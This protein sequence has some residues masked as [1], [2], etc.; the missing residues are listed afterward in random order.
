MSVTQAFTA[1]GGHDAALTRRDDDLLD[2]WPV[3]KLVYRMITATPLGWSTRLGLYGPW[4]SGKTSVL[5]FLQL[6]AE[7]KGDIIVRLPAWRTSGEQEF[8]VQFYLALAEA[9]QRSGVGEP[10]KHWTKRQSKKIADILEK[11]A[12]KTADLKLPESASYSEI[13]TLAAGAAGLVFEKL[14][15]ILQLEKSDLDAL[16]GQLGDRR[17][18]VFV[19]DLDRADPRMLPTTLLTLRELLD[20]P[21]FV[22][23]LA[24]D[25]D[26]VGKALRS[27]SEAFGESAQH[28]LDK[29]IDVPVTLPEPSPKQVQRMVARNLKDCCPF[30]PDTAI[31]QTAE[32]FP[33]NP[34]QAKRICRSLSVFGA[35]ADRHAEGQLDWRGIILQTLLRETEPKVAQVVEEHLLGF[36]SA[37]SASMFGNA[38]NAKQEQ[39]KQAALNVAQCPKD[40]V[41]NKRLWKL[42]E[43]LGRAR[44]KLSL[45]NIH[46]EMSLA[47]REVEFTIPEFSRLVKSWGEYPSAQTLNDFIREAASR[48]DEGEVA[49][50]NAMLNM[51]NFQYGEQLGRTASLYSREAFERAMRSAAELLRLIEFCYSTEIEGAVS[52]ARGDHE[53][54]IGFIRSF[55]GSVAKDASASER[56]LREREL[57]LAAIIAAQCDDPQRLYLDAEPFHGTLSVPSWEFSRAREHYVTVL[58]EVLAPRLIRR[59]I[60]LFAIP[61]GVMNA[62]ILDD[63]RLKWVLTEERSPLYTQ[64]CKELGCAALKQLIEN[65][66]DL[67]SREVLAKNALS[68]LDAFITRWESASTSAEQA[69]R[70]LEYIQLAWQALC[71]LEP[72]IQTR[73]YLKKLKSQLEKQVASPGLLDT[74]DW[75]SGK[76]DDIEHELRG[77]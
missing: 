15:E 13:V 18:I 48:S 10:F 76:P 60:H 8:I 26:V 32:W 63:A 55:Y 1:P 38:N 14:S 12:R 5:N 44:S 4:G 51:A 35:A 56:A 41:N 64:A 24:F 16:R 52:T 45:A 74:P 58:Q 30:L 57:R 36:H 66:Q 46:Y 39:H 47:V 25:K 68:Y 42:I 49:V 67:V 19:D 50:A 62:L 43:E 65:P 20:W 11:A 71:Q 77:I 7:E 70:Y 27:Y 53:V 9:L 31:A 33:T 6:I 37:F 3:A 69:T 17:I 34:R 72:T 75:W 21:G 22:F 54:C 73:V 61:N 29:I 59:A 40:E 28:F 23:V 2:R